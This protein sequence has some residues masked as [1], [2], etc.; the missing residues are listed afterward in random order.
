MSLEHETLSH[1]IIQAA[2]AVHST[3]GSGFLEKV[4]HNAMVIELREAGIRFQSELPITVVYKGFEIGSF[5]AD[6][7][8]ENRM[9]LEFK[10]VENLTR[11]HEVQLV[12]YLAATGIDNGLLINFGSSVQVKRKFR[13]YRKPSG[14]H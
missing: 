13:V 1:R 12:N 5:F 10:A 9:I 14:Q 8:V 11:G 3:L 4:Y 7:L 2:Y 6:M